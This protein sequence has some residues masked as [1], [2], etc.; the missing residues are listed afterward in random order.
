[1]YFHRVKSQ[2]MKSYLTSVVFLGVFLAVACTRTNSTDT[3]QLQESRWKKYETKI[4]KWSKSNSDS[5]LFY[6]MRLRNEAVAADNAKWKAKGLMLEGSYHSDK[7]N[8]DTAIALLQMAMNLA[9]SIQDST[10]IKQTHSYLGSHYFEIGFFNKAEK[11]YLACLDYAEKLHDSSLIVRC[12]N[13]L[14]SLAEN[15][16]NLKKAQDYINKAMTMAELTGD[17]LIMATSMR[18]LAFVMMKSGDSLMGLRYLL[19]SLTLLNK[20]HNVKWISTIYSD[21]GI[22]YRHT[23]PDSAYYYYKK[24][25][26]IHVLRGDDGNIMITQFN[27]ANLLFD[28]GKYREAEQVFMKIYK[29]TRQQNNLIGQAYSSIML[30]SVY[31]KLKDFANA[32]KYITIAEDLAAQWKQPDYTKNVYSSRIEIYKAQGKYKEAVA[33]YEDYDHLKDSLSSAENKHS[34]L[35]LQN[36]FN[37]EKKEFEIAAL[38]QQTAIQKDKLNDRL[39]LIISLVIIIS[40]ITLSL[41]VMVISY[42]KRTAANQ[43]LVEQQEELKKE[44]EKREIIQQHLSESEKQLIKSNAAKDKFFSIIA[45]DLKNPFNTIFGFTDLLYTDLQEYSYEETRQF[46]EKISDASK[47]AYTLLEN[48]LIWAQTQNHSIEFKPGVVD[49]QHM[50]RDAITMVESQA[51]TKNIALSFEINDHHKVL[52]DENLVDT[53]M[54]NLLTNAIKFTHPGGKVDVL[55]RINNNQVEISVQ[56]NGVGISEEQLSRIFRI[57]TKYRTLGTSSEK[58]SGLGLILCKEFAEMQG[59]TIRAESEP[60]KGSRFTFSVPLA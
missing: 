55:T 25:L 54:R 48:L 33:S 8:P 60:G 28:K 29:K 16:D 50:V 22:Y 34:I 9:D 37:T 6:I 13:N 40:L 38:K 35:G 14:G 39:V 43:K 11:E 18:N 3:D 32:T 5:M 21:L 10:I 36:Q 49:L 4:Q 15:T 42:R 47:Q 7:G 27:M 51:R 30:A 2:G 26:D 24:S 53:I 12:Y 19:A 58:G 31:E 44:I 41:G 45:H 1:M 59:G 56:D 52:A 23:I 17:T 57:E 20:V 46:L